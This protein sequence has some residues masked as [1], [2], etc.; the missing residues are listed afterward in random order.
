MV[1]LSE[2]SA[3]LFIG[4]IHRVTLISVPLIRGIHP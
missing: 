1:L 3:G 4:T 2:E